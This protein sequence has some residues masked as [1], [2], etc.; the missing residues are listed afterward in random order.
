[1]TRRGRDT[2]HGT[3]P[4]DVLLLHPDTLDA[5]P[6]QV[7]VS[8]RGLLLRR[9]PDHP[10]RTLRRGAVLRVPW[11]SVQGFSADEV[12]T[13]PDGGTVQV[14]EVVTDAGT[15]SLLVP[16]PGVSRLLARV[17]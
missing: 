5:Y 11:W 9:L 2:A 6:C 10:D 4:Q 8:R 3:T 13:A 16:A 15:L 1:M 7:D 17:G 12:D 14:V